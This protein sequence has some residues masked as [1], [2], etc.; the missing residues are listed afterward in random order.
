MEYKG[1]QVKTIL[2]VGEGNFFFRGE[3][4]D[5]DAESITLKDQ[6][7]GQVTMIKRHEIVSITT[8]GD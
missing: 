2:K 5:E 1:K 3:C 6:K 7:T 4:I 8:P